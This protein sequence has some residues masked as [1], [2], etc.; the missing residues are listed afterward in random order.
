M[1]KK[2]L[3]LIT[4]LTTICL[5]GS[6]YAI[7]LTDS[8]LQDW[9]LTSPTGFSTLDDVNA[10]VLGS[11]GGIQYWEEDGVGVPGS[12]GY[13]GP[14]AGGQDYDLEG[15]YTTSDATHTYIS[16]IVGGFEP[17]GV[18]SYIMGD[19][20]IT[21]GADLYAVA[22]TSRSGITAGDFGKVATVNSMD[23]L[24]SGPVLVDSFV[25]TTNVGFYYGLDVLNGW[26]TE[27][28]IIEVGFENLAAGISNIHLTQTCGNDVAELPVPEPST[29]LL[30]GVSLIGLAGIGR[31][32]F[33]KK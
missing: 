29:M 10:P 22:T 18:S 27:H 7:S 15:L 23:P 17:T 16:A 20:F 19:I 6:A 13:V 4:L 2:F 32:R 1:S 30:M 11:V 12:P 8:S 25:S 14:G 33:L 24:G 21:S 31:K 9:G 28:Y 5:A 3:Q 26:G